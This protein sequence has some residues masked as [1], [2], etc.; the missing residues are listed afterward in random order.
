[1]VSDGSFKV[2]FGTAS[3]VVEYDALCEFYKIDQGTI[4]VGG[5]A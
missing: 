1:M 5:M 2:C 4:E 3:W